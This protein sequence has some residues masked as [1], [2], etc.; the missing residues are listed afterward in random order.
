[1]RIYAK[2]VP[3]EYQE[4]PFDIANY[5]GI[6]L[7]GNRNYQEYF[8]KWA[9]NIGDA[10]TE[11][12]DAWHDLQSGSGWYDTWGEVLADLLPPHDR[13][14]YTRAERLQWIGAL[15]LFADKGAREENTAICSALSL[16]T[17]KPWDWCDLT[18]NCQGEWI[19]CFFVEGEWHREHL[20]VL[21]AEFFNTGTEWQ[22]KEEGD[23]IGYYQY[24]TGWNDRMI[25]REIAETTGA[26]EEN[27]V[28]LK[29]T[30][31]S[32]FASYEEVIA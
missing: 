25:R 23:D 9:E 28:L 5:E 26:D 31:W 4:C 12:L 16:M 30:G 3:P 18:G 20:E 21:E 1:M 11:A 10:L 32:Q 15:E 13:D 29:F 17:G 2:Q 8:P 7:T 27:I 6:I 14:E 24:C 19:E 22:I